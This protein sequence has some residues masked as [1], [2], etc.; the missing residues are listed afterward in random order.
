MESLELRDRRYRLQKEIESLDA[1]TNKG[2]IEALQADVRKLQEVCPHEHV[3][4]S[5][6]DGLWR[7][8]DCDRQGELE[9]SS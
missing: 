8:R 4:E 2:R 1:E 5:E 6:E 3:E 7:C 9:S